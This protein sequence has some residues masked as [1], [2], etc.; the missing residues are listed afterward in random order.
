MTS[1]YLRMTSTVP[2]VDPPSI[3]TSS[4]RSLPWEMTLSIALPMTFSRLKAVTITVASGLGRAGAPSADRRRL[5]PSSRPRPSTTAMSVLHFAEVGDCLGDACHQVDVGAEAQRLLQRRV[6][7]PCE[8]A[9]RLVGQAVDR[10][11]EAQLLGHRAGEL[12]ETGAEA[13]REVDRAAVLD[14]IHGRDHA[15]DAVVDINE[16]AH[17]IARS[18]DR[19]LARATRVQ[20]PLDDARERIGQVLVLAIARE[21]PI[22]DGLHPVLLVSQAADIF[23]GQLGPAIGQIGDTD[24][25][26]E[27]DHVLAQEH[28]PVLALK[29]HGIGGA[30]AEHDR[31]AGLRLLGPTPVGGV[32]RQILCHGQRLAFDHLA[33]ADDRGQME[34]VI[35]IVGKFGAVVGAAILAAEFEA[36]AELTRIEQGP[37]IFRIPGAGQRHQAVDADDVSPCLQ[38]M[39]AEPAAD[40]PGTA[41]NKNLLHPPFPST[42][43]PWRPSSPKRAAVMLDR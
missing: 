17:L 4:S 18:P 11:R 35:E 36:A 6:A 37:A 12:L 43:S 14:L 38:K 20:Y 19:D 40:K 28:M 23:A 34:R 39:P 33:P 2:S 13:R 15:A 29:R 26:V 25:L 7:D 16:I 30:R 31:A 3:T 1:S 27:I 41:S 42:D 9:L 8:H 32:D 5:P 21:R 22:D 24:R 10:R